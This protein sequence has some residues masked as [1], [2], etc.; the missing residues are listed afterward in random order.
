MDR[1][2]PELVPGYIVAWAALFGDADTRRYLPK[3]C[4]SIHKRAA[5]HIQWNGAAWEEPPK[6]RQP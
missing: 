5:M 2:L 1:L 4:Q 6:K 3:F